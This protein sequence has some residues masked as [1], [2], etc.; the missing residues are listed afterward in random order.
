MKAG[1]ATRPV[2]YGAS[3]DITLGESGMRMKR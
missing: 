2:Y 3:I 1:K